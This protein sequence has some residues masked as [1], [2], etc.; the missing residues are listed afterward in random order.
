MLELMDLS[1]GYGSMQVVKHLDLAVDKGSVTAILGAN[2]AGK[3][4]LI[5]SLAGQVDIFSGSIFYRG[6]E[7]TKSSPME[8]VRKG[9]ALVPEGRRLFKSLTVKENLVVGGYTTDKDQA[10]Q[11]MENVISIFPRLGERLNQ[12]S[13]SLSGGEQQMLAIGRA[14]MADP[15]LL[16]IDEL[17][18]GLMPKAVDTCYKAIE[19]L[20]KEGLTILLVEQST[21]RALAVSQSILVLESGN[22]VWQGSASEARKSSEMIDAILGLHDSEK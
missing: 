16:M 8:R 22:T 5:M 3:S 13:G 2:G 4:S 18:L 1:C 12:K 9:I 10:G 17:S 7:I 6:E 15:K 21:Q 20:N 19:A 14:L 11:S